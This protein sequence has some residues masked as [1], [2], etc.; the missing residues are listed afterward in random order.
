MDRLNILLLSFFLFFSFGVTKAQF[1]HTTIQVKFSEWMDTIGFT[2][3]NNFRWTG[4]LITI[5]AELIDTSTALIKVS[6]PEVNKWYT[7][8][9]Y[10]LYDLAG[11]LID[12]EHDTTGFIIKILPV[13]LSS[14]TSEVIDENVLLEWITK[15][16][17]NNYGFNVERKSDNS[18]W[19]ILK[20]IEG[21]GNSNS[22]KTYNYV[23]K[24][25]IGGTNFKYRLKQID[26]DG[27]FQYSNE[28]EVNIIPH[29]YSLFQNFPNPFNPVTTIRYGLP[30]SEEVL[31]TV[32]NITGERVKNLVNEKQRAGK[33][34]VMFDASNLASGLYFYQLKTNN[35]VE[36]KKMLLIK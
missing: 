1:T 32:Y 23:D 29:T 19:K 30:R 13:E 5:S 21:Y 7:L 6:Q 31:L 10:N 2:N 4:S 35:F 20:F 34:E 17:V 26:T 18:D 16:E 36:A 11:N 9:V 15:T 33:Y 27:K 24:I 12:P 14:F 8:K 3:P 25:P 28:I 22:P